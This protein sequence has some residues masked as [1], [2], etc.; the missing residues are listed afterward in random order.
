MSL[1]RDRTWH[2]TIAVIVLD[3]PDD[4]RTAEPDFINLEREEGRWLVDE[5]HEDISTSGTEAPDTPAA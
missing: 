2:V 4:P 1:I 3:E 5:I